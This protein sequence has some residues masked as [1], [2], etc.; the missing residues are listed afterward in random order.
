MT[1]ALLALG[2]VVFALLGVGHAFLTIR[3]LSTPRTFTPPDE[4]LRKAMQTSSVAIHPTANLWRAWLGFNLSHALGVIVFGL[5]I[6]SI[7]IADMGLYERNVVVKVSAVMIGVTYMAIAHYFW[8]RNP[9]IGS[10]VGTAL[11][12]AAAIAA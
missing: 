9:L 8:F 3:D 11:F 4:D 2:G 7:A 1:R 10:G 12:I 6:A 5:T